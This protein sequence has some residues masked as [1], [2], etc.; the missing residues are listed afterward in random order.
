MAGTEARRIEHLIRALPGVV[1][2]QFTDANALVLV[3]PDGD[4]AAVQAAVATILEDAAS[5]LTLSVLAAP[6][7]APIISL[8]RRRRRKA[9][10]A[11]A[12]SAA[13]LSASM[14]AA[15][16]V[17]VLGGVDIAEVPRGGER[18]EVAAPITLL[19][20]PPLVDQLTPRPAA[21]TVT[22]KLIEAVEVAVPETAASATSPAAPSNGPVLLT[23]PLPPALTKLEKTA[24]DSLA[25]P[26][27]VPKPAPQ[28]PVTVQPVEPVFT[29]ASVSAPEASGPP[30]GVAR[31]VRSGN[32]N[33]P[34]DQASPVATAEGG[35]DLPR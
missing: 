35:K 21:R 10:F 26:P 5:G 20:E 9:A 4:S 27:A 28:R 13:A 17:V 7:P 25:T 3:G 24:Q 30:H 8:A 34:A 32:G 12:G 6:R 14:A 2:C 31:R 15:A 33:G 11:M 16:T 1:A 18:T 19:T 29:I 22:D 23:I